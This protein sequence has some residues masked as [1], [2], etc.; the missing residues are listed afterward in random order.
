MVVQVVQQ[1]E[2]ALALLHVAAGVAQV[3]FQLG[4]QAVQCK[5]HG[6]AQ[7][8]L[9]LALQK[10]APQNGQ[11]QRL[12]QRQ[13]LAAH[14]GVRP[15]VFLA[16]VWLVTRGH[17]N[18]GEAARVID[19]DFQIQRLQQRVDAGGVG[20]HL[21]EQRFFQRPFQQAL[22]Q[23]LLHRAAQAGGGG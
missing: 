21:L 13:A 1:V 15:L 11:Q 3:D 7:T 2:Q 22:A 6:H 17:G 19:L 18:K 16:V 23:Q 10:L 8:M 5:L 4:Q 9:L 12:L 14:Q 20:G